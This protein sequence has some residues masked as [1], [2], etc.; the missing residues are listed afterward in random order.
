MLLGLLVATGGRAQDGPSRE[1]RVRQLQA[2]TWE[3][4]ASR[5][6]GELQIDGRVDDEAW[7]RATPV[8]DF[9]QRESFEG[10]PATR[11]TFEFRTTF[12]AGHEAWA[13]YEDAY[14]FLE[15]P[16]RLRP[17]V[18]IHG[19]A[20]DVSGVAFGFDSFARSHRRVNVSYATGG[21]WDGTRETLS[22]RAAYRVDKHLDLS[23][24]Y[25][26]NWVD[27]PSS[28]FTTHLLSARVQIAFRNDL[29]IMSLFQYNSD[30]GELSSN[31]RF[32]WIP[33][34]GSDFFIVYNELDDVPGGLGVKNRSLSVKLNYLF[35][36]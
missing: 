5:V 21:F 9:Y 32:N 34:P 3:M 16:F 8:T 27:L 13:V 31:V 24:S 26:A 19:G 7:R 22:L 36:L 15:S 23:G 30:T 4:R 6:E 17:G 2:R 35:A 20:Y 1:E 14:D 10:L 11:S 29:A 28:V 12:E 25:E 18:V 33:R